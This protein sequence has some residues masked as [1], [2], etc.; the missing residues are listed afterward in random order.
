M[1]THCFIS[2]KLAKILEEHIADRD[3]L[4]QE[5]DQLESVSLD[6]M[7]GRWRGFEIKTGHPADGGLERTNW[8]GK[9]F[10]DAEI[11][12][13]LV[14]YNADRTSLFAGDPKLVIGKTSEKTPQAEI[15]STILKAKT[16]EAKA[17]LRMLEYRG[18]VSA[19]MIYDEFPINDAFRKIDDHRVLGVM[20]FKGVPAP[21]FFVLERDQDEYQ[22]TF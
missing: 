22:I 11:V 6:F 1:S 18:V 12:F 19:T 3:E 14:Y 16:E 5:F 13:P 2:Q 21:Y 9:V 7:I 10:K 4:L 20:D 17:R 8:Y 15:S